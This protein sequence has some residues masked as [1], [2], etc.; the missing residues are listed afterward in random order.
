[1][2]KNKWILVSVG[3]LLVISLSGL[4]YSNSQNSSKENIKV[5]LPEINFPKQIDEVYNFTIENN[6]SEDK[7]VNLSKENVNYAYI[8][9][10]KDFDIE[11]IS[12]K[13]GVDINKFEAKDG[14][15]KYG[16]SENSFSI[17]KQG[18]I[19]YIKK[20]EPTEEMKISDKDCIK[21]AKQFMKEIGM[22]IDNLEVY[23]ISEVTCN[24]VDK[25]ESIKTVE[26][27]IMFNRVYNGIDVYGRAEVIVSLNSNKEVTKFIGNSKAVMKKIKVKK[28]SN[29]D[30]VLAKIKSYK[31]FV[32]VPEDTKFIKIT[33]IGMKYWES[34]NESG[35]IIMQPVYEVIGTA[36]TNDKFN[37]ESYIGEASF[38]EKICE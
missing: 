19:S 34:T 4:F 1:M 12:K 18:K 10:N 22:E 32:N 38:V 35:E 5:D 3:L 8:V 27:Q 37:E 11:K 9:K 7:L 17:N 31:G 21:E 36:Y 24:D 29:V 16:D 2:K 13:L 20:E 26:K 30:E 33:D 28:V 25:P 6:L 15:K 23:G 14:N